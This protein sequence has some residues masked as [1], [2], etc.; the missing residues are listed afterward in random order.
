MEIKKQRDI[1][2]ALFA[3]ALAALLAVVVVMIVFFSR[4]AGR[5]ACHMGVSRTEDSI[6]LGSTLVENDTIERDLAV[7]QN[8]KYS[9]ILS[10]TTS[11]ARLAKLHMIL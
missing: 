3:V 2:I 1:F 6:K 11:P 9:V 10:M 4:K 7:K 8:I 5:I